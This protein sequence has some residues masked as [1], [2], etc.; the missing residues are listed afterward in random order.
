M[1]E[2]KVMSITKPQRRYT[3]QKWNK[4]LTVYLEKDGQKMQL[5]EKD[6]ILLMRALPLPSAY[7]GL[8]RE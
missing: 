8:K 5:D 2:L 6:I 7:L 1:S 4:G 3:Y